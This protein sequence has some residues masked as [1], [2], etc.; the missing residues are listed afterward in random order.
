MS[1]IFDMLNGKNLLDTPPR[2]IKNNIHYEAMT[3]SVAY[4]VSGDAS[5]I[6]VYGFSMPS[7]E[8]LFPYDYGHLYDFGDPPPRFKQWQ[9]HHILDK[10]TGREYDMVIYNI[11]RF[12]SLCMDSNPNMVDSLFVPQRCVLHCTPLGEYVRENRKLFLSKKAWPK[13]KGYAFSQLTK[14]NNKVTKQFVEAC[15]HYDWPLDITM[16]DALKDLG[17]FKDEGYI[18]DL[19]KKID[20]SGNRSK[21]LP[22][23]KKYGYDVKFAYNVVRLLEECQMILDEGDLD[24]TRNAPIL[25]S[26]RAGEWEIERVQ[27]Y[28][29]EKR[30]VLE[31]AFTNSKL[32]M[33]PRKDE[34][35]KVLVD[36]IRMHY[37]SESVQSFTDTIGT[38]MALNEVHELLDKIAKRL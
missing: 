17:G 12:F 37:G 38:K 33:R 23:I 21:R 30:K 6:D 7:K 13:F 15:N 28:F 9:Q 20:Q 29:E 19:F 36:C 5:D 24:L 1:S 2:H 27:N 16:E 25:K 35:Q 34:I 3:G 4:G 22:S 26:I 18:T 32:P 14:M 8:I 31:V 10:D 11:V